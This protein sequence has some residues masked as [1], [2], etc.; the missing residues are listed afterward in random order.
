MVDDRA[1]MRRF[2]EGLGKL[3]DEGLSI[4]AEELRNQLRERKTFPRQ[5]ETKAAFERALSGRERHEVGKRGALVFGHIYDCGKCNRWHGN[6]AGGFVIS[7]DG[8]AVTNYHVLDGNKEAA[9]FGAMTHDGRV[10][11]VE[12]VLAASKADDVAVVRLAKANGL[13]PVA[14]SSE[15][16][17]GD[18][19]AVGSHP[20]GQF[21][22]YTEGVV[23]RYAQRPRAG[24]S[25]VI[26]EITA[27][28]AVGSS[29]SPVFDEYGNVVGVVA[30]THFLFANPKGK[31]EKPSAAQMVVKS[32]VLVSSILNLL[33]GEKAESEASP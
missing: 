27:D 18:S 6:A 9:T 12:E 33:N 30:S 8:L 5:L 7:E 11:A 22:T 26:M 32:C 29:G 14:L 10:S 1:V 25:V 28:Y 24:K 2:E 3:K 19:V 4:G 13:T 15:A 16:R 31:G 20:K 23:S 17:A 21:Y